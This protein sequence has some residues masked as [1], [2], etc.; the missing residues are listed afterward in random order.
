MYLPEIFKRFSETFPAV[1]EATQKV[2]QL[3]SETGP[4]DEKT[5]HLVQ[6]GAAV[7]AQSKGAV[8]SH[9]RRGLDAGATK[10]EVL[11]TILLTTNL[12]GFPSMIAAFNW[13]MEVLDARGV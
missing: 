4:L 10:E 6:L 3:C 13:A 12:V 2:G 8:R 1:A 9:V 11:Q 7:G 5:R